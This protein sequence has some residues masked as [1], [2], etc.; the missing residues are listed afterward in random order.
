MEACGN[1]CCGT[2]ERCERAQSYESSADRCVPKQ[3]PGGGGGGINCPGLGVD[4]QLLVCGGR[5]YCIF[6]NWVCCN[7][8]PVP[9]A[10]CKPGASTARSAITP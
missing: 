9:P 10:F 4:H 3:P 1:V 6:I 8:E 5:T 7:G 2:D